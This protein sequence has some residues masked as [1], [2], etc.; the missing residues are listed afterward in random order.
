MEKKLP[1]LLSL[2]EL[3]SLLE[4]PEVVIVDARGG[5]SSFDEYA[6]GHLEGALYVDLENELS[7]KKSDAADGGRH[8][9]PDPAR[10]G[11]VL[12]KL[13]I[14]PSTRVVVYDDK[15]G[16]NAAA[17]FWWM[18][19]AAGHV[20]VQVLNGS[21]ASIVKAGLPVSQTVSDRTPT[22]LY[23]VSAWKLPTVNM[24]MVDRK[25]ADPAAIVIDVRE[26]YRYKGESEPIDLVAGH[27]PGAV[28]LP[29][30]N[31]LE[32]DGQF[33]TDDALR[34]QFSDVVG[35]RDVK[36]VIVHCGSG[37]TA[38]HTLLAME[39]AGFPGASLY[40]GSWSEW[41]RNQN[42]IAT[43]ASAAG[44]VTSSV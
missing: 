14:K 15:N 28:N 6:Q 1:P 3:N 8:P 42:P 35:A 39:H 4:N 17:R 38:C 43:G 11:A 21:Y 30:L 7:E 2:G 24:Q 36:N 26:A 25:R 40:V 18:M 34:T 32:A 44:N 29:Y 41:S 33:K 10:F 12:G 20:S 27:I 37:V 16:A 19:R 31:N 13:G 22:N 9:L 5:I 23:P